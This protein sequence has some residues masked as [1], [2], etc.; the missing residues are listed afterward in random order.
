[1]KRQ[2]QSPSQ[3]LKISP[4]AHNRTKIARGKS[5]HPPAIKI[6]ILRKLRVMW[7]GSK[8]NFTRSLGIIQ[9]SLYL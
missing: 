4:N 1:M 2:K 7:M 5:I 8:N 9:K 6:S 3:R